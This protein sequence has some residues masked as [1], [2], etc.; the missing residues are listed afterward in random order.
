MSSLETI[1]FIRKPF[2]IDAVQLTEENLEQVADWCN[3]EIRT[4]V[5]DETDTEM[6]TARYI[7][8][9]VSRPLNDRQTK[10]F[11]NDWVLFANKGF[12]IYTPTAFEENFEQVFQEKEKVS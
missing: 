4:A 8:V 10:A 1:K 2:T 5:V 6:K 7:K 12:K 9:R 3:G 11:I